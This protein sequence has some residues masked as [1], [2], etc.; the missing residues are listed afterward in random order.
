[1]VC[2]QHRTT[3]Q[4]VRLVHALHRDSVEAVR[5]HTPAADVAEDSYRDIHCGDMPVPDIQDA[6]L[7][8]PQGIE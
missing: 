7:P 6:V 1:M 8:R 2:T 5:A 3:R 4:N